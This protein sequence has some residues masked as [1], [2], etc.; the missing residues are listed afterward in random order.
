MLR[1]EMMERMS[2]AEFRE[3]EAVEL[4]EPFGERRADIRAG[5]IASVIANVNRG[6]NQKAFTP[7]DFMIPWEIGAKPMQ[8]AEQQR[9]IFEAFATGHNARLA[10][11]GNG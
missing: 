9:A 5:I 8:T 1:S 6:K 7:E 11:Q 4:I 3:W 2:A 10:Q